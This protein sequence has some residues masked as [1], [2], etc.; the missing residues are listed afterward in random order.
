MKNLLPEWSVSTVAQIAGVSALK[1]KDYVEKTLRLIS[2]ERDFLTKELK[3]LGFKV[4]PSDANF[5]LFKGMAEEFYE[6]LAESGIFIRDCSNFK[7]LE[8]GWYRSAVR[9]RSENERLI[10]ALKNLILK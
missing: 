8:K 10:L 9:T 5:I 4:F 3:A 2:G 7:G 1:E 6:S